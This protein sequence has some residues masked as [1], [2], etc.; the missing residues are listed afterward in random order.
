MVSP[1]GPALQDRDVEAMRGKLEGGGSPPMPA[2]ITTILSAASRLT[3]S[4]CVG[5]ACVYTMSQN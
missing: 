1:P 2:L 3:K 4:H 5:R